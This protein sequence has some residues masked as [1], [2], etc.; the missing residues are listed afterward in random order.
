MKIADD[1]RRARRAFIREHHPDR[2][3]DAQDFIAGL[4]RLSSGLGAKAGGVRVVIRPSPSWRGRI[5]AVRRSSL[6]GS[7]APAKTCIRRESP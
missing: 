5:V 7:N 1:P 4:E 6:T 3:G 2:G